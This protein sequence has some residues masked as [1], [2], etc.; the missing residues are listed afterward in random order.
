M[1]RIPKEIK[2]TVQRFIKELGKEIPIDKA[3]I[4]GSYARGGYRE[5]SD[6]N[7]AIFSDYFKGMKS[8]DAITF[9]VMKAQE[10]DLPIEPVPYTSDDLQK[11]D[12]IVKEIVMSG[13]DVKPER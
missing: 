10:Y 2:V 6:V 8:V 7:V 4:Y 11:K 12:G 5:D 1:A 9:L 13:I 3:V